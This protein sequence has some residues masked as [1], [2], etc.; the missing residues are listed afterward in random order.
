MHLL[1]LIFILPLN[2]LDNEAFLL[3]SSV[4]SSH[5]LQGLE[6]M[7]IR[8]VALLSHHVET[9]LKMNHSSRPQQQTLA[10]CHVSRTEKKDNAAII[11]N[12]V[13]GFQ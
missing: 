13:Y 6:C 1:H 12:N 4:P 8:G 2:T 3:S 9:P 5:C 7:Q 11:E 10:V